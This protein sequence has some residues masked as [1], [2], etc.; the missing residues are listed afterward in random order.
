MKLTGRIF[1]LL[2]LASGQ[3]AQAAG[4]QTQLFDPIDSKRQRAVPLKVYLTKEGGARPV[5]LF[6]H[7][8][9]GSRDNN[10]YLGNHWAE[11]GYVAVFMQH[12]GSDSSIWRGTERSKRMDALK[13]AAGVTA[14]INRLQDVKFVI[15]QLE[16]WAKQNG[17]QLAGKLD[18]DHIGLSGHSYGAVTTLGL[19][20]RKFRIGRTFEDPRIDAFLP[21]SAQPGKAPT[22][23]RSFG[24]IK[25]PVLC[26]TGTK[27][28][29]PIDPSLKPETR[30]LVYAAL[31]AGSKYQLVFEGGE[32]FAFGSSGGW[33]SKQ[34]NP[35]HHPTIQ[36]IST[37]FWD[38][39]LKGDKQAEEWLQSTAPR[40]ACDLNPK[41]VWEWK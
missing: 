6:S 22:P 31:P 14:T 9:G 18:L 27:D 32:H 17:H 33:K 23:E 37:R 11:N 3:L 41:D 5:V 7:G 13:N 36:K 25:A 34:Q 12:I 2:F 19:M 26:M 15:D 20:G 30:R 16:V 35:K 21:M 1:L 10:P 38:A 4:V 24:H 29:S 39:Y 40:K 8:L 28:G